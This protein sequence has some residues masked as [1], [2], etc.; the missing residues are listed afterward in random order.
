MNETQKLAYAIV[1]L[2][3]MLHLSIAIDTS[4][5]TLRAKMRGQRPFDL[6]EALHITNLYNELFK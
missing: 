1:G 5:P 4:V 2:K 6:D 3:S